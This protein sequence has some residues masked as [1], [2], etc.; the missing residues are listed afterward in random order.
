MSPYAHLVSGGK[1]TVA[2]MFVNLFGPL[3]PEM[4]DD[5][6]FMDRIHSYIPGWNVPKVNRDQLAE[7]FGLVSDFL[8]S[9]WNHLRSQSRV[10]KLQGR[11]GGTDE[12]PGLFR[13][14][15]SEGPR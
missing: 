13:I 15:V 8:S 11:P 12:N 6:A 5:T 7:H 9:C 1:A 10:K 4:R 3:P 14:E 2:K